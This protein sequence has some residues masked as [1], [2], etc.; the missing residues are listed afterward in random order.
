M[1]TLPHEVQPPQSLQTLEISEAEP[2]CRTFSQAPKLT[3]QLFRRNFVEFKM[4]NQMV[5]KKNLG[6]TNPLTLLT[7]TYIMD[8]QNLSLVQRVEDLKLLHI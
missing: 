8:R 2:Q 3:F 1:P 5:N 6:L 4:A 7:Q